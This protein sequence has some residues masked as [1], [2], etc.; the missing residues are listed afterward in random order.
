MSSGAA[1]LT[2]SVRKPRQPVDNSGPLGEA[3]IGERATNLDDQL[4]QS[5]DNEILSFAPPEP[6]LEDQLAQDDEVPAVAAEIDDRHGGPLE[7]LEQ[8]PVVRRKEDVPETGNLP[9][10]PQH[11]RATRHIEQ[12]T[13]SYARQT[14][15]P[16]ASR[17]HGRG[18]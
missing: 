6:L 12:G 14:T 11:Q 1:Q 18:L 15:V 17:E 16:K 13:R 10:V 5:L 3:G 8:P 4:G 7:V 2:L 9:L